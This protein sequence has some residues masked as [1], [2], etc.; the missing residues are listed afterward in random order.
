MANTQQPSIGRI[1]HYQ[2]HGSPNG[3]HQSL[4]RAAI[5]TGLHYGPAQVGGPAGE[6]S[7]DCVDLC[8][9]NPSGL[10][11]NQACLFDADAGPGTWRWPP[12]V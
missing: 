7:T 2:A 9:L 3:Q 6:L 1:V 11:F 8:V 12:R 10:F 5:I 4:P